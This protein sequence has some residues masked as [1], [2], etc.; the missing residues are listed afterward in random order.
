[1]RSRN[2][3]QSGSPLKFLGN[4]HGEDILSV[5]FGKFKGN[6]SCLLTGMEYFDYPFTSNHKQK[7]QKLLRNIWRAVQN[8]NFSAF[9][10]DYKTDKKNYRAISILPTLSKVYKRLNVDS[11]VVFKKILMISTACDNDRKVAM[12][13]CWRWSDRCSSNCS[14]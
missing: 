8:S 1:M 14:F 4:L 2:F 9:K 13:N 10:K 12:I 11:N 5:I 7:F 3:W 6:G